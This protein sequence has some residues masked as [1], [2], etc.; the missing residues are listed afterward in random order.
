MEELTL[1]ADAL[2]TLREAVGMSELEQRFEQLLNDFR[3][4][5][6]YAGELHSMVEALA[7]EPTVEASL[8][9]SGGMGSN[10]RL[11]RNLSKMPPPAL[12][13]RKPAPLTVTETLPPKYAS[14][15]TI[16]H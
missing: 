14:P 6:A 12:S 11:E 8:K 1:D 4:L 9:V 10:L 7:G 2:A 13:V 3:A 15:N 16:A 5:V